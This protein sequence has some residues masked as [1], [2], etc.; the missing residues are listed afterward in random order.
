MNMFSKGANRRQVLAGIAA[1]GTTLSMPAIAQTRRLVINSNANNKLRPVFDQIVAAFEKAENCEVQ[2]NYAD[3]ESY[4]TSIRSFLVTNP[5]DICF[6]FSGERMRAFVRRGLFEDITD[7]WEERGFFA[8]TGALSGALA[9]E[10]RQYG[11]PMQAS[12]WG[13]F[14]RADILERAGIKAPVADFPTLIEAGRTLRGQNITPFAIGSRRP[15]TTAGWFD[16]LNLRINGLDFHMGLMGGQESYLDPKLSSVFDRW[17]EA[18]EAGFFLENHTSYSWEQ[19]AAFYNQGTAA[20]MLLAQF[21]RGQMTPEV[22]DASDFMPFPKVDPAVGN[23]EEYPV[24]SLHIPARAANK[25]LARE[26]LAF[27][28]QPDNLAQWIVPEGNL[29]PRNDVELLNRDKFLEKGMAL[30]AAADGTSQFYDRDTDPDM[31]QAGLQGFQQF[32]VQPG[33]RQAILE[34]LEATRKRVFQ[35]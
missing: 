15:W 7:L 14:Y 23:F 13:I 19:A 8:P 33:E 34:R 35:Q 1:A 29:P 32:M 22:L 6:W 16:Y 21:A 18:I 20:M 24:D 11:I 17:Q 27:F 2:V 26:F 10:N 28:Y 9:V 31:A 5:P 12:F 3:Y 25:E 4:N 30:L